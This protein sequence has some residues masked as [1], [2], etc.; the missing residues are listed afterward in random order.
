MPIQRF[1]SFD[2]ARRALWVERDHPELGPR[3]RRLW[4]FASRLAPAEHARGVWKFRTIEEA[5]LHREGR[6]R[7]RVR[8]LRE[9]RGHNGP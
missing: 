3:I 6:V 1:H 9:T 5:N 2:D 8:L 4:A 7:Q